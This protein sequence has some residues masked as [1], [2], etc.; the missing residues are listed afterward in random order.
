L[1]ILAERTPHRKSRKELLGFL[2]DFL[3]VAEEAVDQHD[4]FNREVKALYGTLSKY[5]TCLGD[6]KKIEPQEALIMQISLSIPYKKIEHQP[7]SLS[8]LFL[9]HL[10]TKQVREEQTRIWRDA[11]V[12]VLDS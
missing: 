3:K 10:H 6:Q 7:V 5:R 11:R 1:K 2:D 12:D 4:D 8:L 9:A